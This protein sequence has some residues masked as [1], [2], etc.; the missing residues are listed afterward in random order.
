MAQWEGLSQDYKMRLFKGIVPFR[1]H[2]NKID[3][4]EKLSQNRDAEDRAGALD[5]LRHEPG[6][7]PPAIADLM[8]QY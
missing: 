1:I 8:E 3:A 5:G 7:G 2:V 4:K 6:A